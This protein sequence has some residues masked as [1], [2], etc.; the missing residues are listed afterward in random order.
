MRVAAMKEELTKKDINRRTSQLVE[1]KKEYKSKQVA[2]EASHTTIA[3]LTEIDLCM[4]KKIER[5]KVK[6]QQIRDSHLDFHKK[7]QARIQ[8]TEDMIQEQQLTIEALIEEKASYS[9]QFRVCKKATVH[10]SMMNG[11]KN[12][13]RIRKT[14][15][16]GRFL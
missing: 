12:R 3:G 14:K 15:D 10:H 13:R 2:L 9:K 6:K 11:K 5:M 16:L 7:L 1:A 8:E 4:S